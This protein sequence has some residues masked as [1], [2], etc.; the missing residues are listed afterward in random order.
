MEIKANTFQDKIYEHQSYIIFSIVGIM[1]LIIV[2]WHTYANYQERISIAQ[3]K[4]HD[5]NLHLSSKLKII[6][7]SSKP[8]LV[9][10]KSIILF[11]ESYDLIKIKNKYFLVT[12]DTIRNPEKALS[13]DDCEIYKHI[14][15][16][17]KPK[18]KIVIP[19]DKQHEKRVEKLNNEIGS[20]QTKV[21]EYVNQETNYI[22]TLDTA[23]EQ[24]ETLN[25]LIKKQNKELKRL[26]L[27][28]AKYN[29]VKAL[30]TIVLEKKNI[31]LE[32]LVVKETK[33]K[34]V[35]VKL[36]KLMESSKPLKVQS[37]L[38]HT[39]VIDTVSEYVKRQI[40]VIKSIRNLNNSK[41]YIKRPTDKDLKEINLT[42]AMS[43]DLEHVKTQLNLALINMINSYAMRFKL[44]IQN[45]KKTIKEKVGV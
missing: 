18:P 12:E 32:S 16:S 1:V 31:N 41:F 34:S 24:I 35:N 20:L 39:I 29:D 37:D 5:Y 19:I 8:Q 26:S 4:I 38:P 36:D 45:I 27:V 33:P 17:M 2:S 28:E 6:K 30:L 14:T 3:K 43:K 7:G 15:V 13:L 21:S 42:T 9:C 23:N 22:R 40:Y 44:N 11:P 10:K 25:K